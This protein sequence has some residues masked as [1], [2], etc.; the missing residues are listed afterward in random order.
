MKKLKTP[1]QE[2]L[3][4]SIRKPGVPPT[5]VERPEK[6]G[7]YKRHKKHKKKHTDEEI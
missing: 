2:E 4:K 1:T 3:L 7:G 6:G 5:K